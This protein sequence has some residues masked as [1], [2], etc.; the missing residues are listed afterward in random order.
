M[1][2]F[3]PE[4]WQQ[5]LLLFPILVMSISYHE[6]AHALV[7]TRLGDPT[8]EREGRVT[9]NPF[10]HIDL[11]GFVMFFV[12][13]FGWARAVKTDTSSFKNPRKGLA[14]VAVSG[15]LANFALAIFFNVLLFAFT[16]LI[17]IQVITENITLSLTLDFL[18]Y[19]VYFNLIFVVLNLLPIPPLDGSRILY[20]VLPKSF[21]SIINFFEKT[22]PLILIVLIIS[23]TLEKI[24]IPIL[25]LLVKGFLFYL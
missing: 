13:G 7:A 25:N 18:Y 23:G 9:T 16:H 14:L 5:S 1:D 22:S 10:R 12:V 15:A 3:S 17:D 20:A 11:I 4:W 8:P 24:I 2:L 19:G 6:Y 21:G